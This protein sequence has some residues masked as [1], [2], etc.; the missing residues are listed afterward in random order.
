MTGRDVLRRIRQQGG[1][2]VRQRGS[3]VRVQLGECTTTVPVHRGEDISPGALRAIERD[4]AAV[5]GE[6][7]VV[8]VSQGRYTVVYERDESGAW[9]AHVPEVPG[10][11]T[12]GRSLRQARERIREALGLWVDDADQAELVPDIRLPRKAQTAVRRAKSA[13]TLVARHQQQ[14][15]E[16]TDQA[17]RRLAELGLSVRDTGE[18][19]GISHQRAQQILSR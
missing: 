3:H 2:I 19:L 10:C 12:Y 14:A 6:G 1:V 8:A 16:A 7:E 9:N 4:L 15:A 18:V 13:R 11:H 17:V 5:R